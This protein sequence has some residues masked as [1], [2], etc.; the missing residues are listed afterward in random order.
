MVTSRVR[1]YLVGFH[2]KLDSVEVS[3]SGRTLLIQ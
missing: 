2:F 3:V 1:S